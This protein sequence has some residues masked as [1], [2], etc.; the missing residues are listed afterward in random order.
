MSDSDLYSSFRNHGRLVRINIRKS[1]GLLPELARRRLHRKRG[2]GSIY[3]FAAKHAMM[4]HDAVD[5]VLRLDRKFEKMPYL[6]SL[7]ENGV[8]GWSKLEVVSSIATVETDQLWADKVKKIPKKGLERLVRELRDQEIRSKVNDADERSLATDRGQFASNGQLD[9]SPQI[10]PIEHPPG[11]MFKPQGFSEAG[12]RESGEWNTISFKLSPKT[13]KKL[14]MLKH[15]LEK[16]RKETL[17]LNDVLEAA[18]TMTPPQES[19]TIREVCEQ[20]TK[21]DQLDREARGDVSR[22]IPISVQRL[23]KAR[24]EGGFCAFPR[25]RQAGIIFHHTRRFALKPSHDPDFIVLLCEAHERVAQSNLI[26]NE[27]SPP[28]LWRVRSEAPWWD[29]KTVVDDRV[30]KFRKE[31]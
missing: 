4:S 30:S 9:E 27:E 29:L 2:C 5:R 17:T 19:V 31:E 13:E 1:A 25:C 21:T 6:R 10:V 22:N 3:E 15:S 20:C 28:D 12:K 26:E 23:I 24:Q 16:K 11:G 18:L 8:V 14:R 7:M